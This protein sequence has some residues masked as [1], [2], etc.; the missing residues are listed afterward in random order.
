MADV[1]L[2]KLPKDFLAF[3]S[4]GGRSMSGFSLLVLLSDSDVSFDIQNRKIRLKKP[5]KRVF[6]LRDDRFIQF[7]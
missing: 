5:Y 2:K 6:I 3:L 4:G 1:V 7:T